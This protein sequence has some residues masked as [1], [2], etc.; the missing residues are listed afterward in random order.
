MA[1]TKSESSKSKEANTIILEF[2]RQKKNR[3]RDLREGRG[4]L[5]KK[6]ARTI[7]ELQKA[8]EVGDSVQPVI[9][10]VKQKRSSSK[11]LWD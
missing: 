4:R 5:F 11:G 7:S 9:V 10:I 1:E 3:I 2:G 6:V 8:G